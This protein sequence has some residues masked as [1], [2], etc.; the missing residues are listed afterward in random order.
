MDPEEVGEDRGRH[1][2]RVFGLASLGAGS[3]A[4]ALPRVWGGSYVTNSVSSLLLLVSINSLIALR[5]SSAYYLL[6]VPYFI[7]VLVYSVA[8]YLGITQLYL[9][10]VDLALIAVLLAST[11]YYWSLVEALR[12]VKFHTPFSILASTLLGVC[13][14]LMYPLRLALLTLL[15]SIAFSVVSQMRVSKLESA[16]AISLLFVAL[17]ASPFLVG[18]GHG[19]IAL[20]AL[21]TA[22]RGILVLSD[23][24]N[25]YRGSLGD[26]ASIDMVLKPVLVVLI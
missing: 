4:G 13:L 1:W 11:G 3:L 19:V 2:G 22:M 15:E 6:A 21:P 16:L 24:F 17:Y 5:K 9:E 20:F 7:V 10:V 12:V 25:R 26:V 18:V 8:E 23:R 14:G